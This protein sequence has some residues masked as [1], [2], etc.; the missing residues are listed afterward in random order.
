MIIDFTVKNFLSIR[1]EQTLSLFADKNLHIHPDN[2]AFK[3]TKFGTLKTCGIM[4]PNASGKSN[5]LLALDALAFFV[6]NSGKFDEDNH[7]DCYKPYSLCSESMEKPTEFSIEFWENGT[8]FVYSVSFDNLKVHKESLY[9]YPKTKPAKLFERIDFDDWRSD[10]AISHGVHYKGGKKSFVCFPNQAYLSVAG[11]HPDS[12]KIIRAVFNFFKNKVRYSENGIITHWENDQDAME[13]MRKIMNG[14]DLGIGDFSFRDVELTK[15]QLDMLKFAPEDARESIKH[16]MSKEVVFKH[17]D[18]TGN[19]TDLEPELES[20]G[21][22][23][24]FEKFPMILSALVN[25]KVLLIDEIESS[26]HAHIVELL[27]RL[28]HDSNVNSKNAQLIFSTHSFG[29]LKSKLMRKDQIWLAEKKVGASTYFSYESF[30]SSLRDNSPFEKWYDE[31]RLGGIPSLKYN[32]IKDSLIRLVNG[33]KDAE[34][35]AR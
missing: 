14:V 34:K 24:L 12:P 9:F 20:R 35:E 7:I 30:D 1:D 18:D 8:R 4:G 33:N 28:F 10:N 31:G 21:T 15:E 29:I 19:L 16:D 13:A 17:I 2:I 6:R 27:L 32:Q 25:G 23:R 3:E 22:L 11:S 26:Y 5:L